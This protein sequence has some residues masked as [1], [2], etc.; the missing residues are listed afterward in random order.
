MTFDEELYNYP[1]GAKGSLVA[2]SKGSNFTIQA[3]VLGSEPGLLVAIGSKIVLD[4]P[5]PNYNGREKFIHLEVGSLK[6]KA[7][8]VDDQNLWLGPLLTIYWDIPK[9]IWQMWH[10]RPPSFMFKII[11]NVQ[12]TT[13]EL[14]L[15]VD[16][17]PRRH[18]LAATTTIRKSYRH[19]V[20]IG[21]AHLGRQ[22]TNDTSQLLVWSDKEVL[23]KLYFWMDYHRRMGIEHFY[24]VD[25]EKDV[26]NRPYLDILG[27]HIT[28]LRFPSFDYDYYGCFSNEKGSNHHFVTGQI[29]IENAILKFAN[30]EWLL[31][32]DIDEF[33]SISEHYHNSLVEF[34]HDQSGRECQG[35]AQQPIECYEELKKPI[36]SLDIVQVSMHPDGRPGY[37]NG[38]RRKVIM[39]TKVSRSLGVHWSSPYHPKETV[40]TFVPPRQGW[41]AHYS[42]ELGS[43]ADRKAA[44]PIQELVTLLPN[45]TK[46]MRNH[47]RLIPRK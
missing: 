14:P 37:E 12:K 31:S 16:P 47:D 3:L 8:W 15:I 44:P 9:R 18:F 17:S 26:E 46:A 19:Y 27:E 6:M 11:D 28:Y 23:D 13:N 45:Q 36:F 33:V 4:C 21:N 41:L 24:I 39:K 38:G 40:H 1:D 25:N 35:N 2:K 5:V 32:S 42:K 22:L 20:G 43:D 7:R 34:V 30:T 10:D 29:M